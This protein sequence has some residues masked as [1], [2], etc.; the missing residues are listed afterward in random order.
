MDAHVLG[1][2]RAVF[3]GEGLDF[4]LD[5]QC[6]RTLGRVER[7]LQVGDAVAVSTQAGYV[8]ALLFQFTAGAWCSQPRAWA[9]AW[10][11]LLFL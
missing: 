9:F 3:L 8:I 2:D 7:P 1:L 5:E 6:Q 11:F 4:L 10:S